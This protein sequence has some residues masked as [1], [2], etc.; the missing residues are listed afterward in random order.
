MAEPFRSPL[1]FVPP[2]RCLIEYPIQK[3][4]IKRVLPAP[5]LLVGYQVA[6]PSCGVQQIALRDDMHFAEGELVEETYQTSGKTRTFLHPCSV[7]SE[8]T[9]VCPRCHVRIR[10][11]GDALSV[12]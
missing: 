8:K 4:E 10:F 6:C 5:Q 11:D 12:E 7:R 1:R 9:I 2:F 3:G